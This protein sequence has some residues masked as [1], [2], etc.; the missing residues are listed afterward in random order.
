MLVQDDAYKNEPEQIVDDIIVMFIA[1]SKTVQATTTNLITQYMINEDLRTKLHKELDP[2]VEKVKGDWVN[3]FTYEMTEDL[4]YTKY[5]YYETMR[6]DTPL[7]ISSTST[8]T[9]SCVIDGIPM[10]PGVAFFINMEMIHRD[11]DEWQKP[12]EYIPERFDPDS[13]Y[14]TR[15]DGGKRNPLAFGPFLGGQR[16]CLGKTF[17]ELTLKFTI[18]MYTYFF[19][20]EYVKEEHKKERPLYQFG[21]PSVQEIPMYFITKNKVEFEE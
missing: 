13:E 14:F 21:S 18:P 17:A 7:A 10:E 1:G 16:V 15:P 2:L 8:V 4:V 12:F 6:Y 19:D 9:Q 3:D 20:F 11:K 5:A